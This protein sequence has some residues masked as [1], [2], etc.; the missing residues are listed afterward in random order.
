SSFLAPC[1]SKTAGATCR[2]ANRLALHQLRRLVPGKDQLRDTLP[3]VNRDGVLPAVLQD[4]LQLTAVVRVDGSRSVRQRDPVLQRQS[5][6]RPDLH[7]VALGN[8][9][10]EPGA[11]GTAFARNEH[12]VGFC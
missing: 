5:R 12:Q 2:L 1:T 9:E 10:G 6:P 11:Y 4:H 3:T 7:F 8:L